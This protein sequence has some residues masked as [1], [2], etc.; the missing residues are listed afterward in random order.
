M[1]ETKNFIVIHVYL[2]KLIDILLLNYHCVALNHFKLFSV[3][4]GGFHQSYL[5][6]K[7]CIIVFLLTN[8]LNIFGSIH[9]QKKK[10]KEI[11]PKFYPLMKQQFDTKILSLY[12]D[13]GGE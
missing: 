6:I 1:R 8:I 5:L 11:F 10:V 9:T 7:S 3:T 13:Y 4:H 12:T 2:I